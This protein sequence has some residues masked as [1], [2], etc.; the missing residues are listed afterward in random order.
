[1]AKAIDKTKVIPGAKEMLSY[2]INN[3]I[4]MWPLVIQLFLMRQ[5]KQN[6]DNMDY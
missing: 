2:F 3:G 4:I 6:L 5:L 1:M